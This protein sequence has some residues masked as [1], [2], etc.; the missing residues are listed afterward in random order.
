MIIWKKNDNSGKDNNKDCDKSKVCD[1]SNNNKD[2]DRSSSGQHGHSFNANKVS[3]KLESSTL[4]DEKDKSDNSKARHNDYTGNTHDF[5][6]NGS[7][8]RQ[9]EQRSNYDKVDKKKPHIA[10]QSLYLFIF[11]SLQW[12]FLSQ[13]SQLL[14]EPVIL[15]FVYI[16][17]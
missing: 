7:K 13:I 5:G 14:L 2:S 16:F 4:A 12:K 9:T 3:Q 17:R 1:I 10:Y 8:S 11:L 6:S 15:N